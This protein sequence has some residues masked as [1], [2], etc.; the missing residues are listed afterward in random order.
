MAEISLRQ[1]MF[2][3]S[4]VIL[5]VF[6]LVFNI[7]ACFE[8]GFS[9]AAL[10]HQGMI[11]IYFDWNKA[12]NAITLDSVVPGSPAD[13]AGLKAGDV[14]VRVNGHA[15]DKNNYTTPR[16]W[17]IATIGR[18]IDLVVRHAGQDQQMS[19]VRQPGVEKVSDRFLKVF[20]R[21][22][23]TLIMLPY[24]LVGLWGIHRRPRSR[25][26]VL[27][28]LFCFSFGALSYLAMNVDFPVNVFS[29]NVPVFYDIRYLLDYFAM[30]AP[31]FWL[32]M[33]LV[34]PE[35]LPVYRRHPVLTT[36][37]A[38]L[39]GVAI[40][41]INHVPLGGDL[42]R[43]ILI[44]CLVAGSFAAGTILLVRG[45][46]RVE[47]PL[48]RRQYRLMALGMRYGAM[49]IGVGW[50]AILLNMLGIRPEWLLYLVFFLGQI[51]GLLIPFSFFNTFMEGRLLET[52][53]ALRK[54]VRYLLFTTVLLGLYATFVIIVG[55][56]LVDLFDLQNDP[57]LISGLVFL[58]SIG[59]LPLHNRLL[60]LLEARI[61]P[62]KRFYRQS[63]RE[64]NRKLPGSVDPRELLQRVAQWIQDVMGI[65]PVIPAI[66][67]PGAHALVMPAQG[68]VLPFQ[69]DN[70]K[71]VLHRLQTGSGFFWDELPP[72]ALENFD[73]R[74]VEW[75]RAHDISLTLPMHSRGDLLGVLN[76]GKK[77]NHEDFSGEDLDILTEASNQTAL[78]LQNLNLQL[79][80][81]EKNRLDRELQM[82]HSIQRN[83][84]P[85]TIPAVPGMDLHGESIPCHEVAGDYFD[86]IPIDD[87]RTAL[88]IADVSGK[89]AGA[90][91]LMA[92][93]QACLRLGLELLPSL[94]EVV[95]RINTLMCRNTA[96][97]QFITFFIG[98]WDAREETLH[99]VNAG[100]NA[101]I[102]LTDRSEVVELDSTGM[103]LGFLSRQSYAERTVSLPPDSVLAIFTDGLEEAGNAD[104]DMFGRQRI[105]ASL[106]RNRSGSALEIAHQLTADVRAFIGEIQLA[107]DL[108]LLTVKRPAKAP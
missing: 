107:D 36:M 34:I 63:L 21:V 79:A 43:F 102:L 46:H 17:G 69:A 99:Y 91:L 82:A 48:R 26:P 61:Y 25:E 53:T 105:I 58:A 70:R 55:T 12:R 42:L 56:S 16:I 23:L 57:V 32:Y 66:V 6:L 41:V 19:I 81:L 97:E 93:L 3:A 37:A 73:T 78:T 40:N 88:S 71:S 96:P 47:N 90:A 108:T 94:E 49:L 52:E 75:A 65:A 2:T 89:G 64:L 33:F 10:Q 59:F 106:R 4:V 31:G 20:G 87:Y 77:I 13:K 103:I 15:L 18:P 30:L 35:P 72:R 80:T 45:A 38:F 39:P 22:V 50:L 60:R 84:M 83:L 54:K 92:N 101:P 74:E 86:I 85:R 27:I 51:G 76:I 98:I 7:L 68:Q 1:K 9:L 95:V 62:E 104:G 28:A 44:F 67:D 24:V 8:L 100:H 5:G 11:G 29:L 14:L